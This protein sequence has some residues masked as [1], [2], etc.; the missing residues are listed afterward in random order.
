[1]P[2]TTLGSSHLRLVTTIIYLTTITTT[3]TMG[4]VR[5]DLEKNQVTLTGAG[6]QGRPANHPSVAT[7]ARRLA[8]GEVRLAKCANFQ[9]EG[10]ELPNRGTILEK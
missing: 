9:M 1:M 6:I 7:C 8:P 10:R 2:S 4:R 3:T 5:S